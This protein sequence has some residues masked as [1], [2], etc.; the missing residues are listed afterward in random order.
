MGSMTNARDVWI[1]GATGLV[2]REAVL[3]LL[4]AAQFERVLSLVRRPSGQTS[5][6]LDERVVD[7]EA[8]SAALSA[9]HADV[10][11]CCLGSTIKQAG[12]QEQFRHIDFDYALTFARQAQ[13]AGARHFLVVTALGANAS[14][15][16]FYNRVKGELERALTGLG[17][18]A[19]TIV[20]PSLLIGDRGKQS[21]LG[22]RLAAPLMSLLPK[23]VRGIEAKKVGRALARLAADESAKGRRVVPS[24]E[25][26]S[27]GA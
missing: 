3:A 4:E 9:E 22:E 20:R 13:A 7:F 24:A 18:E 6:K 12:S 27:L 25:L 26:H 16:V 21:R 23:S 19:L 5:P 17:F 11:I 8:L 1:V 2:G 15:R 10:A 14:S